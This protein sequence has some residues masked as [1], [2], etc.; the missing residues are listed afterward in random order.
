[1]GRGSCGAVGASGSIL[2]A[3]KSAVARS[4]SNPVKINKCTRAAAARKADSGRQPPCRKYPW[5]EAGDNCAVRTDH[6]CGDPVMRVLRA[7]QISVY[8][9]SSPHL[10]WVE[11]LRK[12]DSRADEKREV[13]PHT[14]GSGKQIRVRRVAGSEFAEDEL[15][16]AN[17]RPKRSWEWVRS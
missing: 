12:D 8:L 7:N 14:T 1:M 6:R 10:R 15:R 16:E 3:S 13:S 9:L 5:L 11:C 2:R 17:S 4:G